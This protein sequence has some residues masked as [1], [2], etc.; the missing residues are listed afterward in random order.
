MRIIPVDSGVG[1]EEWEVKYK[2][3][4]KGS[5]NDFLDKEECDL[6][7]LDSRSNNI[8]FTRS[9]QDSTISQQPVKTKVKTSLNRYYPEGYNTIDRRLRK[10]VRD[11]V[12]FADTRTEY[13][14]DNLCNADLALLR[15]K[16]GE[17][18][19]RQVAEMQENDEKMM[20]CLRPYKNGLFYKSR[21]QTKN[22][23]ENTLCDY[24]AYIDEKE[25]GLS[26][27][28]NSEDFD[29]LQGSEEELEQ[30]CSEISQPNK[31]YKK[32][33]PFND[34]L[35]E[36]RD[37]KTT[38]G[39]IG[40]W[41]P[42]IMLSPVE[43]PSDEYV[44]PID[45]LQYLVETVSEYLAKKEEEISKYGSLPE[46]GKSR[47][48]FQG[49]ART[50]S[51]GDEGVTSKGLNEDRAIEIKDRSLSEQASGK[52]SLLSSL[53]DKLVP[54]S[55]QTRP[56]YVQCSEA[57]AASGSS[58]LSKLL[59]FM[60][61]SP[62][63]APVA[64]VSPTQET[65][66][67]E[68]LLMHTQP[69]EAKPQE[70]QQTTPTSKTQAINNSVMLKQNGNELK[71]E[72]SA[73][74]KVNHQGISLSGGVDPTSKILSEED[75]RIELNSNPRHSADHSN[76]MQD[77]RLSRDQTRTVSETQT[78]TGHN[79]PISQKPTA[80]LGFFGPLKKSFSSLVSPVP[81]MPPQHQT[82]IVFPVFR[83]ENDV[84]VDKFSDASSRA[85]KANVLFCDSDN[86]PTK[87]PSKMERTTFSGLLEVAT[88]DDK[89]SPQTIFKTPP[90][91]NSACKASPN[92]GQAKSPA[93]NLPETQHRGTL[94]TSWFSSLF[95]TVPNENLQTVSS[96]R[97]KKQ[98]SQPPS[99]SSHITLKSE[100]QKPVRAVDEQ[101]HSLQKTPDQ[102]FTEEPK[103]S[104]PETQGLHSTLFKSLS[105]SSMACPTPDMHP[106]EGGLFSGIMKFVS[107]VDVSKGTQSKSVHTENK[108]SQT[109]PAQ[110]Y[111]ETQLRTQQAYNPSS[112]R[113]PFASGKV[114]SQHGDNT[115]HQLSQ[116]P[117]PPQQASSQQGHMLSDL[118]KLVSNERLSNNQVQ[119]WQHQ[120]VPTNTHPLNQPYKQNVP[121]HQSRISDDQ[122]ER[123]K[124][125]EGSQPASEQGGF[126]CGHLK[127]QSN[128]VP[129]TQ[130]ASTQ[131]QIKPK[132]SRQSSFE[133]KS[134]EL[135]YPVSQDDI[136]S[137]NLYGIF[138]SSSEE[139]EQSK[140]VP[141][142][143]KQQLSGEG[144]S[145]NLLSFKPQTQIE[146]VV[147]E[148]KIPDSYVTN[149]TTLN[150]N[151][152]MN[153]S[154]ESSS[155]ADMG[156]DKAIN[157]SA[158]FASSS[159]I[160]NGTIESNVPVYCDNLDLRTLVRQE[161]LPQMNVT[162]IS[163]STGHL[164]RMSKIPDCS[165][166]NPV[167]KLD[168]AD[169]SFPV[170]VTGQLQPVQPCLT[171]SSP[172]IYSFPEQHACHNNSFYGL[173]LS[174]GHSWNQ[175]SVLREHANNQAM[176]LDPWE[177]RHAKSLEALL[178]L[179]QT[180][181]MNVDESHHYYEWMAFNN[182]QEKSLKQQEYNGSM[183]SNLNA[184][185]MWNS[186]N[187]MDMIN[188]CGSCVEVGGALNLSKKNNAKYGSCQ[189]LS[190]ESCY[191]LN[192]VAYLEGYYEEHPTNLS[193]SANQENICTNTYRQ[194]ASD[195]CYPSLISCPNGVNYTAATTTDIEDYPYFEDSEWYQ[196]WL[197]LLEQGMWWP[198]DDGNCGYFI[199]TDHEYI[200]ALLTDESGQY[201][202]ACTPENE[203][204]E[205]EQMPDNYPSALL[206]NEMVMVC[207]FK[208]PL[209]NEDE[210]FWLPGE[211]QS[212]PQ[213][214]NAPLD[215]SD[216][217][218]RGNEIMNLNLER[219]SHMFE[220][221]IASQNQQT[222]DF[223]MYQLNKVK[224]DTRKQ[225]QNSFA[226]QDSF[227]EV[228]DLSVNGTNCSLN[229]RI[230]KE[231]LSQKVC[232][233]V[234]PTLTTHSSGVYSCYQPHQRRSSSLQVKHINDTSEEEWRKI[235]Q[236]AEDQPKPIKKISSFFSS[237][238]GKGQESESHRNITA[239]KMFTAAINDAHPEM[240]QEKS[241]KSSVLEA[242]SKIKSASSAG[243]PAIKAKTVQK[244][245]AASATLEE[246][247]N[248]QSSEI[249]PSRILPKL[250]SS[251]SAQGVTHKPKLARQATL[252][253][254]SSMPDVST[255]VPTKSL[256]AIERQ[257]DEKP[258]E[259]K[260]GGFLGFFRK[261][262]RIEEQNQEPGTKDSSTDKSTE[263]TKPLG[264]VR[265]LLNMEKA[266][267]LLPSEESYLSKASEAHHSFG[268]KNDAK[269]TG[270]VDRKTSNSERIQKSQRQ[271]RFSLGSQS[272]IPQSSQRPE[273]Q[274]HKSGSQVLSPDVNGGLISG[275]SHT[276][277][278]P[279]RNE[280]E[281]S[282]K[283]TN[284]LFGFSIGVSVGTIN[285]EETERKGRGLLSMFSDF[286]QQQVPPQ[287]ESASQCQVMDES[288]KNTTGNRILSLFGSSNTEKTNQTSEKAPHKEM[289]SIGI[290][291]FF[292]ST[293]AE[294]S[295]T[296]HT[297]SSFQASSSMEAQEI[298]DEFS[299][300]KSQKN[301]SPTRSTSQQSSLGI[302]QQDPPNT[303]SQETGSLF[304]GILDNLST[305]NES[306]VKSLFC[307]LG[308]S[309]PQ[310]T[311]T[312]QPT[313]G[314]GA[315][316][317]ISE[318]MP[319][320]HQQGSDIS[321]GGQKT[322]HAVGNLQE[323]ISQ[324]ETPEKGIF[325]FFSVHGQHQNRPQTTP[326]PSG[327][328]SGSNVSKGLLSIFGKPSQEQNAKTCI[329]INTQVDQS[330]EASSKKNEQSSKS[331]VRCLPSVT[332]A[333]TP[334]QTDYIDPAL[335]DH[336]VQLS[337]VPF[338][339]NEAPLI[340]TVE[341]SVPKNITTD[342][343]T[344]SVPMGQTSNL[345][346][347]PLCS[348]P[349]VTSLN[350]ATG[351]LSVFSGS[352][353]QNSSPQAGS[354]LG[355][356][357]PG[358]TGQK[359]IPGKSL[360]SM[361]SSPGS[362]SS[363][364]ADDHGPSTSKEPPGK[365]LFSM[366][367]STKQQS[368]TSLLGGFFPGDVTPKDVS[369]QGLLSMFGGPSPTSPSSQTEAA[370]NPPRAQGDFNI[371][372]TFSQGNTSKEE[373]NLELQESQ[374]SLSEVDQKPANTVSGDGT[375]NFEA[376]EPI[377]LQP[378]SAS[379]KQKNIYHS[380]TEAENKTIEGKAATDTSGMV[381]SPALSGE[382][383]GSTCTWPEQNEQQNLSQHEIHPQPK[384]DDITIEKPV[385]ADQECQHK[386]ADVG[387]SVF[388]TSADVVSGFMS[389]MFSGSSEPSK[390]PN[391]L[392]S[393]AQTSFFMSTSTKRSEPQQ[394][395]SLFVFPSS[396]PTE[397][398]KSDL[399]GMFKSHQ[400]AKPPQVTLN[401]NCI[402]ST[403]LS[404]SAVR[405]QIM[406]NDIVS[407]SGDIS[408][409][410][411][412]IKRESDLAQT[413]QH[414]VLK[415]DD[416]TT[417]LIPASV[418]PPGV[419]SITSISNDEVF[420][421]NTVTMKP[422]VI[423]G[424][425]EDVLTAK[426]EP[427][428]K[429][430]SSE[431]PPSVF[432]L[433]GLSPPKFSFLTESEDAR[434]SLG[435]LFSSAANKGL[436]TMTQTDGGG[437]FSGIKSF[438]T[439]LFSE[440]KPVVSNNEPASLFGLCKKDASLPAQKQTSCADPAQSDS[441]GCP[442]STSSET[443]QNFLVSKEI[444]E[445]VNNTE[446][447]IIHG[448]ET[449]VNLGRSECAEQNKIIDSQNDSKLQISAEIDCPSQKEQES[450]V[451]LPSP[452]AFSSGLQQEYKE[453]LGAKRLVT[454]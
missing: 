426:S 294:Q 318:I 66:P 20:P 303:A 87:L 6:D 95:K 207:G 115:D 365:S 434:K 392:F 42:E 90:K 390:T 273:E 317:V 57:S 431:P 37:K 378:Q 371:S 8:C 242:Q 167:K 231:L 382:F 139:V 197:L 252:S 291:S 249:R 301:S 418:N 355:G 381:E 190:E 78:K 255:N 276:V 113:V 120:N 154:N 374:V 281:P 127:S 199:Y 215:L 140:E 394:T 331:S 449:V 131:Q 32:Y 65:P 300:P 277:S 278:S 124:N 329:Q 386:P 45:E 263:M 56:N 328:L 9:S 389:K 46:P 129:T 175:N 31:H 161:K 237:L 141:H 35:Q 183:A 24:R 10:K 191:S 403:E 118:F 166:L 423:L 428:Q 265:E 178:E 246:S 321:D 275:G 210:L 145:Q 176:G 134:T 362:K 245:V 357:F 72:S 332:S 407:Y 244:D 339:S 290:L 119:S 64:V 253:Q 159:Q 11:T 313:S 429:P 409:T 250:P 292:N 240:L 69:P 1:V 121:G 289:S 316:T 286:A 264:S 96:Q 105:S 325:S 97:M 111:R 236:P 274:V 30:F 187:N 282:T 186:H 280:S 179:S 174:Y 446:D 351:L 110:T 404:E 14:G 153:C 296:P 36:Y 395:T 272:D 2:L 52:K 361:F 92:S 284:G 86:V 226:N 410:G 41:A 7:V 202:Y 347:P 12:G 132:S 21:I 25:T 79:E 128:I 158:R 144:S 93:H 100:T 164:P 211:G 335:P 71:S 348:G 17:L 267:S 48:S 360:F 425:P 112:S 173:P 451:P 171:W 108:P 322:Q 189:S 402:P 195:E 192:S 443:N 433:A 380:I 384:Q 38:K 239:S 196:Q 444:K 13:T 311:F 377:T 70:I 214:F 216:A 172:S 337:D 102:P 260:Q 334:Q 279:S 453:P 413:P 125:I 222:M 400:T 155:K 299:G 330:P 177:Y 58:G 406:P 427:T 147:G 399:L 234:C 33:S 232:I 225:T 411:I 271:S 201:V 209:Y 233:S 142:D 440:K 414:Q 61:R 81:P 367:S 333:P 99:A 5:L 89:S 83:S 442:T 59:S 143:Q 116:K 54:S 238:V 370:S 437:L 251:V 401:S 137:A 319:P 261:A 422:G 398:L 149:S 269:E 156:L 310:P 283:T 235:V 74:G 415:S 438:S 320:K 309:S 230:T 47:L 241:D 391:G 53:T 91:S 445:N 122:P 376:N 150:S 430:H 133:S 447:K 358:T 435:S 452:T 55:K 405:D 257:S 270:Y 80:D 151:I 305:Y 383:I 393:S 126:F 308:G 163:N 353:S 306:P 221:S 417:D 326:N 297:G 379:S 157:G 29:E 15:Q 219:F 106:A 396:L 193:Y 62:S 34:K 364:D 204:W 323:A 19:L 352:G 77:S 138:S 148:Q 385:T 424:E 152:F 182:S 342:V 43:E 49:S 247:T 212:G 388:D 412:E 73:L 180:L 268:S 51:F 340:Q 349:E 40:G 208:I 18:V 295:S 170:G 293:S 262:I 218:R 248:P 114:P 421:S 287:K 136:Q 203:V 123:Q 315:D 359:N 206:H 436:P 44:D 23:A 228:L 285:K 223:S 327:F 420:Q 200:Y 67:D 254:Q 288:A 217:Y 3:W 416:L 98:S 50:D 454:S 397:N 259:H 28:P 312:S 373:K 63:P 304:G 363:S 387:K 243:L 162:C 372:L 103:T 336:T 366:F 345:P 344:I 266:A 76:N 75:S 165:F 60:T 338:Q 346:T 168:S 16:R 160:Y 227:P 375:T 448:H 82:Q 68:T 220:R 432:G 26:I 22:K 213:L 450:Q 302:V 198:A 258:S 229:N 298:K 439:S 307:R 341:A 169:T 369:G 39:K 256:S 135:H 354:V 343:D 107:A 130:S 117:P 185:N 84:R 350:A 101:T 27:D 194:P 205:N 419:S 85:N 181:S 104:Q 368:S 441:A 408:L 184:H 4:S 88:G 224:M 109:N 94:E 188:H 324:K 356:I 146:S 314:L